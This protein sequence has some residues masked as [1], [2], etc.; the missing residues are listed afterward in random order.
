MVD[1]IF[2]LVIVVRA[3]ALRWGAGTPRPAATNVD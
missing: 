1:A 2:L 3:L